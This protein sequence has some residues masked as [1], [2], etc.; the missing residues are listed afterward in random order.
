MAEVTQYELIDIQDILKPSD[1]DQSLGI[2]LNGS[3]AWYW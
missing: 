3:P 2:L 1:N